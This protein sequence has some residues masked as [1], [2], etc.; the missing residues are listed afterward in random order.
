MRGLAQMGAM[1]S[2]EAGQPDHDRVGTGHLL[3]ALA[4]KPE[5][6]AARVLAGPGSG[7]EEV[8]RRVSK[9]SGTDSQDAPTDPPVEFVTPEPPRSP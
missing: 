2:L 3:L 5:G 4:R 7:Y 9:I 6:G 1:A 8:R